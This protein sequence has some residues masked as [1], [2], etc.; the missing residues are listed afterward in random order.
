MKQRLQKNAVCNKKGAGKLSE[1]CAFLDVLLSA[2]FSALTNEFFGSSYV[3]SKNA[4]K[5]AHMY[6]FQCVFLKQAKN[7]V[8]FVWSE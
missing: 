6:I 8:V 7:Y 1:V 4:H 5:N 2:F 3:F